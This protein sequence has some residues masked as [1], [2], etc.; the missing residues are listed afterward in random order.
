MYN[1]TCHKNIRPG[2]IAAA[3]EVWNVTHSLGD[4]LCLIDLQRVR[5][6]VRAVG[7]V[8]NTRVCLTAIRYVAD[9][10]PIWQV[11]VKI[12]PVIAPIHSLNNPIRHVVPLICHLCS[13][14]PHHSHLHT[15]SLSFS[16]TTLPSLRNTK[17]RHPS[18]S[19]HAMIMSW[20]Q[21]QHTP[22]TTY[23]NDSIHRVQ[24]TQSTAYTQ[25]SVHQVQH[26]TSTASTHDCLSSLHSHDYELMPECSFSFRC[27]SLHNRPPLV[28]LPWQL[29]GII[30][31]SHSH[32]CES[33]NW[34]IQSQHLARHTSTASNYSSNLAQSWP[35]SVS[36]TSLNHSLQGYLLIHRTADCKFPWLRP[37]S[38][39]PN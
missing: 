16:S 1:A 24:H 9:S 10:S 18:L 4:G 11:A 14:P 38:E 33:T 5:G 36:V 31:L 37:A 35:P 3:E 39:S 25:Y 6:S 28:S 13:Y 32:L 26:R 8:R 15:P 2:R 17:I 19:L 23:T 20:H 27:A 12:W 29:N 30:T 22:S 7:A 34:L 21:V